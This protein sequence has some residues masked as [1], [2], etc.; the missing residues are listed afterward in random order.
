MRIGIVG[1]G[2]SGRLLAWRLAEQGHTVS[3]FEQ[4]APDHRDTCSFVAAG[5]LSPA[6]ELEHADSL[7]YTLGCYG[8]AQWPL[9]LARLATPVA[10]QQHGSLVVAHTNDQS[11][12]QHFR[13]VIQ[14]KLPADEQGQWLDHAALTTREPELAERFKHALYLPN[15]AV[16]HSEQILLALANAL[17]QYG[18]TWHYQQRIEQL[19]PYTLHSATQQ[20]D[21]DWVCDCRGMGAQ[22]QWPDLRAVRGELMELYAPDVDLRHTVRLLHPRYRLYVVPRAEHHYLLGATEIDSADYSPISVRSCLELLSAAYSMH[23]GFAEAR[24]IRTRTQCRP[25]F[26]DN[27]PRVATQPGLVRINGLYRHGYL[28]APALV[29]QAITYIA[30]THPE[31]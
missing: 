10:W 25:A 16:I 2:I 22:Q 6:A 7:I 31:N 18:I 12:L 9:L 26:S 30:S 5:M 28:L 4:Q 14:A 17:T 29:E 20:Y 27:A 15:E 3:V 11:E 23:R 19:T 13:S 1:A 8:L 21:F 24:I